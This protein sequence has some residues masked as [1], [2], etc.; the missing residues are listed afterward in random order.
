MT[1][2]TIEAAAWKVGKRHVWRLGLLLPALPSI[3]WAF[4]PRRAAT[5]APGNGYAR[6]C[7]LPG[8]CDP[9]ECLSV[10]APQDSGSIRRGR[11][12]ESLSNRREHL[13]RPGLRRA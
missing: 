12:P 13:P 6:A 2:T 10:A 4:L 9:A 11:Q 8:R 5:V 1:A 7:P 3:G